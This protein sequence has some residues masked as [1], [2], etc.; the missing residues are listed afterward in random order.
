MSEPLTSKAFEI[1]ITKF[2][3]RSAPIAVVVKYYKLGQTVNVTVNTSEELDKAVADLK[4]L[5]T[6]SELTH[7]NIFMFKKSY[8]KQTTWS[9]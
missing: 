5:T 8:T 4:K 2:P 3:P 1:A 7:F 6:D 9:E